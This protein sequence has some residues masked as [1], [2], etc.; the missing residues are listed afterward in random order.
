MHVAQGSNF[1][2]LCKQIISETFR[3]SADGLY[4]FGHRKVF[5]KNEMV[6]VLEKARSKVQ[7]KKTKTVNLIRQFF[8]ISLAKH[9]HKDK[10]IKIVR[11]QRFWR[12][13]GEIVIESRAKEFL[14]KA[15][16]ATLKYKL[17]VDKEKVEIEA[18]RKIVKLF[19]RNSVRQKVRKLYI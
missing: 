6:L 10:M 13:R 18:K 9:K 8:N 17:I 12:R 1:E 5:C 2:D 4:E 16:N 19:R 14:Q 15:K 3:G 11:I 7:E